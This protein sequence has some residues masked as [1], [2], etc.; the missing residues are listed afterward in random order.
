VPTR[1]ALVVVRSRAQRVDIKFLEISIH[2]AFF[3]V[4]LTIELTDNEAPRREQN[5]ERRTTR[6]SAIEHAQI[7]SSLCQEVLRRG[8]WAARGRRVVVGVVALLS[9]RE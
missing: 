3:K 2:S 7:E 8:V 9:V 1:S 4:T 6:Q 5:C